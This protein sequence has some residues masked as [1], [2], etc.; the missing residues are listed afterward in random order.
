MDFPIT[1]QFVIEYYC[2]NQHPNKKYSKE[3]IVKCCCEYYNVTQ[4]ELYSGSR[5]YIVKDCR[6]SAIYFMIK[7]GYST[8]DISK[9]FRLDHS[10]IIQSDKKIKELLQVEK[11]IQTNI[12]NLQTK[13]ANYEHKQKNQLRH[14][15]I[16]FGSNT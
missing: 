11:N 5:V 9:H 4:A 15:S 6:H 3:T 1:A 10:T 16:Q 14:T 8:V 12:R 7:N 2:S 13:I